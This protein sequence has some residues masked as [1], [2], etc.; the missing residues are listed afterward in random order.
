L[1]ATP[2]PGNVRE[3]RNAIE[4]ASMLWPARLLEPQALRERT[5]AHLPGSPTSVAPF[6]LDAI[7]RGHISGWSGDSPGLEGAVQT[8]GID[9]STPVAQ[10]E[11]V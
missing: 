4:R 9:S 11:G 5:V 1:L 6:T 10:A 8:L 3:L 7:E 2:W